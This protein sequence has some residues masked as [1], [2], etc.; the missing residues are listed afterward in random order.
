MRTHTKRDRLCD[1][2]VDKALQDTKTDPDS[3]LLSPDVVEAFTGVSCPRLQKVINA[4]E[5][6]PKRGRQCPKC[7]KFSPRSANR[8][9]SCHTFFDPDEEA[10]SCPGCGTREVSEYGPKTNWKE[11]VLLFRCKKCNEYF[12]Y[13]EGKVVR[14][15]SSHE[16]EILIMECLLRALGQSGP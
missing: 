5:M 10:L 7:K 11:R 13:K 14:G 3:L 6:L 8:C 2:L 12:F 15:V 9:V 4:H 1:E 16:D